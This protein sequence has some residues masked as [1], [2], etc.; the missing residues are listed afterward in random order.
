MLINFLFLADEPIV[1][2]QYDKVAYDITET[3]EVV[4]KVQAY[5]K[6]EFKW[7]LGT[8]VS[9][10]HSSSEGHYVVHTT[11]DDNDVYTS[12]LR[13]SNI[14]K[15]DYGDYTCQIINNL[16]K[17]NTKIKLQSKGPPEKPSKLISLHNGPSYVTLRWEPGF[18]GGIAN[19]KY[20]V[21][22][23]KIISENDII[24]EGCGTVSKSGDWNE[25]DCH[26]SNPCNITHLEQHQSYLFK[27]NEFLIYC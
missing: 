23:K 13:I 2:H 20:F 18:N 17:V 9:P 25:V 10:L 21:S 14:K 24:V 7:Y 12:V 3:A 1:L 27:V 22:Y 15:Q 19:T 5:P 8:N 11:T 6:P 16:G 26:Q 4:C